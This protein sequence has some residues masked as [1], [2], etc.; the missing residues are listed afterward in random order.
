MVGNYS[1][2]I[3]PKQAWNISKSMFCGE[4]IKRHFFH[5]L[6]VES[7]SFDWRWWFFL[8]QIDKVDVSVCGPS[9]VQIRTETS[10]LS[11]WRRK[12]HHLQSKLN[13]TKGICFVYL[14]VLKTANTWHIIFSILYWY[15]AIYNNTM[16]TLHFK[17]VLGQR[18]VLAQ[19][20][21]E[22]CEHQFTLL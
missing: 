1:T 14:I 15:C 3:V 13:T 20:G 17:T 19:I 12:N 7:L 6:I 18:T 10:T 16:F 4:W 8:L 5:L 22:Q 11:I 2:W 21:C 9:S